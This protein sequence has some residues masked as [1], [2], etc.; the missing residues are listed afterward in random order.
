MDIKKIKTNVKY[1]EKNI[2]E[3]INIAAD[4]DTTYF[5]EHFERHIEGI[6]R[7][8]YELKNI[9]KQ[10]KEKIECIEQETNKQKIDKQIND[11]T[12]LI[13][14]FDYINNSIKNQIKKYQSQH[15]N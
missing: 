5:K 1:N 11:L 6:A 14:E 7:S 9:L 8:A 12:K 13:N 2:N 4:I 3:I 10:M 15:F